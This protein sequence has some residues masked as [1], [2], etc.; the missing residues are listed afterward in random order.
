MCLTFLQNYRNIVM[1]LTESELN[2]RKICSSSYYTANVLNVLQ[3]DG[4]QLHNEGNRIK[5]RKNI[6]Q[7][8]LHG[9]SVNSRNYILQH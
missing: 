3:N 5:T 2:D 1:E 7:Q 8:L 9:T 6:R 4:T